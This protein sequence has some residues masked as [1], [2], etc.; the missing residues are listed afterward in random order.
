MAS[1]SSIAWMRFFCAVGVF[2]ALGSEASLLRIHTDY[3]VDDGPTPLVLWHGMGDTCC[4]NGIANLQKVIRNNISGI[5]VHSVEIGTTE[6]ED[7][8]NSYFLQVNKQIDQVCK[9]LSQIPELQ[10]GYNAVGLSQ[11]GQFLRAVAQRC[12]NP[13]IKNLITLGGQH[14][15]VSAFPNCPGTKAVCRYIRELLDLGAYTSFVQQRLVQA[16]YWHDPLKEDEYRK[17]ST[18]LADINNEL[19]RN[20]VYKENLQKLRNFVMVKFLNDTVVIPQE[21]EWFGFYC[22][23]QEKTICSLQD[24][25]LYQEDWLGLKAMNEAGK[26]KFL[27][28]PGEHIQ[29]TTEWFL[30]T[31]AAPYLH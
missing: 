22:P 29:F 9:N 14:Q 8:D 19:T 16:Q 1:L 2:I 30:D 17:K 11:G 20:E 31:I 28:A 21:S 27:T 24:S 3:V 23:G 7:K 25:T 26:V 4:A 18:F 13:P 12:P 5:F 15:G 6:D 10:N